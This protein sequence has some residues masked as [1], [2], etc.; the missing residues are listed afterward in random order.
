MGMGLKDSIYIYSQFADMVFGYIP[1]L[2]YSTGEGYPFLIGDHSKTVF[3]P[4]IDDYNTV[5]ETFKDLF[6]MLHHYYFLWLAF[7][8]IYL[9]PKKVYTFATSLEA[10]GFKDGPEGIWPL[11]KYWDHIIN[12]LTPTC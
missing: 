8:P 6:N 10:V 1:P 11:A 9:N 5:D 3:C 7:R 2:S 12:W 4:F